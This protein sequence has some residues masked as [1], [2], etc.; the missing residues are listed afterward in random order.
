M[1]TNLLDE[2]LPQVGEM[3]QI[4]SRQ[5]QREQVFS[6]PRSVDCDMVTKNH[7]GIGGWISHALRIQE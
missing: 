3:V 2:R 4:R 1:N 6:L 7:D 5:S